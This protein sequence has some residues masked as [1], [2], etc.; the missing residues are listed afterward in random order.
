MF[1]IEIC[2]KYLNFSISIPK[3]DEYIFGVYT[4]SGK[5]QNQ[6]GTYINV[7][8][9]ASFQKAGIKFKSL[10]KQLDYFQEYM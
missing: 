6:D 4:V 5:W 2:Q 8:E 1:V 7:I 10:T 9:M 3:Y